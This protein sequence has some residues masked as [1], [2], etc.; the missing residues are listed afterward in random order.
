MG[1]VNA[2]SKTY[3]VEVPALQWKGK[4]SIKATGNWPDFDH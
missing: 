4:L 1:R 3:K 2:N